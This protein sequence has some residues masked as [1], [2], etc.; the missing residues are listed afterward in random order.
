MDESKK[1]VLATLCGVGAPV[2]LTEL[3]DKSSL[4]RGYVLGELSWLTKAGLVVRTPEAPGKFFITDEGKEALIM[5]TLSKDAAINILKTVPAEKCFYFHTAFGSY[6][7]M[8]APN[9]YEFCEII[10]KVDVSSIEFHTMRGD[11]VNWI[12]N[13]LGDFVLSGKIAKIKDSGLKGEPLREK[14]YETVKTRYDQLRNLS[15]T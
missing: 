7:N 10:K 11:F 9:L 15:E 2:T 6:A 5:P 4:P 13:V 12:K 3:M 14:I 1:K 8:M